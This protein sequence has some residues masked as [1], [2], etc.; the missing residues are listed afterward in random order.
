[1]NCSVFRCLLAGFTAVLALLGAPH[2][3]HG[4]PL[5]R[6][7]VLD[8]RGWDAVRDGPVELRGEWRITWGRFDSPGAKDD[9]R[10]GTAPLIGVPGPW[11]ALQVDGRS[12]GADGIATYALTV[13][14]DRPQALALLVPSAH[15]AMRL[16]MNGELLAEQGRPDSDAALAEPKL[17]TTLAPL[18]ANL[19]CP[20][21]VVAH[22]SNFS[23]RHGGMVRAPRLGD[24]RELAARRARN[25]AL[26][27]ALMGGFAVMGLLPMMFF[28]ARRKETLALWF[29]LFCWSMAVYTGFARE[30]SLQHLFL[31]IGWE[32]YLK[33]EYLGWY[34]A[35]PSFLL[36]ARGLFP[37]EFGRRPVA[38]ALTCVLLPSVFVLVGP[39]RLYSYTVPFVQA[40]TVLIAVYAIGA[41]M[42]AAWRR[43]PSAWVCL[44]GVAV[45]AGAVVF[46]ILQ[47]KASLQSTATPFG[48]LVFALAPAA[49]L[50]QRFARALTSE[51]LRALE[52]RH[53]VNLLVRATRA[54]I[55]DWDAGTDAVRLS[56]RF[57]QI[58][59]REEGACSTS[60]P[61]FF[62]TVH[63]EDREQVRARVK[64]VLAD[65][66][67]QSGQREHPPMDFRLRHTR[68][69]AVWVHAEALSITGAD[70]R[71]LRYICSLIDVTEQRQM[72]D[73]LRASRDQVAEQAVRLERQ[74]ETLQEHVRLR[75]EVERIGRHDLKTPLNSVI[76]LPRLLREE[77]RLGPDA[78][79]LLAIVERAG[80]RILSMVN[81]SLDLYKME[82][83][84]YVFRPDAVDL[85]DLLG[86]VATDVGSHAAP[87]RVRLKVDASAAPYAWAEEL[88]CYSLLANLLKNAVEA[89]PD[90]GQVSV[91]AQ[92]GAGETV[93]VRI[94]NDGAVPE[95]LRGNFFRKYAT[96]GKAGGSGLGAYSARLMARVQEGDIEMR[97]SEAAGT[98]LSVRLRAAPAGAV[99][100]T[101]R[102][103][104]GRG[105]G[106]LP[107]STMP[108]MRVLLVDD[109][110]YNLL[111]VRRFLPSPP[112]TVDTA[113]NGR[114]ALAAAELQWPDVLF[115]D[116]DMPVMGGLQAVQELRAMERAKRA[117]RCRMVALSSYEDDQTRQR[118][119]A[120]GFDL[121]LTKP[122]TREAV[123]GV[124]QELATRVGTAEQAPPA[125]E[126]PRASAIGDVVVLEPDVEPVLADFMAS[127]RALIAAMEQAMQSGDRGEVRRIAHQLA[128]SFGLY[129]FDWAS[130]RSRS[131]EQGSG[132][133]E[134]GQLSRLAGEL[135]AHL[136]N[137][138][139]RF[140][141]ASEGGCRA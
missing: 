42:L 21:E 133:I 93:V 51:E 130:E 125:V 9:G 97:T 68:G 115:M 116:L 127:R 38:I 30:R 5:A 47:Y 91:D 123:Q 26:D 87:R 45:L 131:I 46:D 66:S 112:F 76:A 34:L 120:A 48:I 109:D 74:N 111:I 29:G 106:F 79:E 88:L 18:G 134:A 27:V 23:H 36:F 136:D 62:D 61:G 11:N 128:G 78:D 126:T 54:G 52:Q 118:S 40:A 122:V 107:L 15:S 43:R 129:G 86:K 12:A 103:T 108:P 77:R 98:T 89:S 57:Q 138:E 28:A 135:C 113:V 53:R 60:W 102:H 64:S 119:L 140:E 3:A 95:S 1:M 2:P 22:L 63:A 24:E 71:P 139:I 14:C 58:L 114:L 85:G 67:V 7:G 104:A 80:Y 100:T 117:P 124:L 82:D 50:T 84:R 31:D 32:S 41:T 37:G 49:V 69:H 83:G 73:R 19:R 56:G 137:V 99:P 35:A 90:G 92:P 33:F 16:Y 39:A 65:R 121:Y 70:G 13:Q 59:G 25:L 6:N 141:D 105:A 8:L 20:L 17:A 75:E 4:Q 10:A 81:L 110:E 55:L 94:H 101:A 72:E 44:G 132:H 96:S